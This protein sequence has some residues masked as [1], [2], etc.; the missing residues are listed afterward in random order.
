M[1][2]SPTYYANVIHPSHPTPSLLTPPP[3]IPSILLSFTS[4]KLPSHLNIKH[5]ERI[6][7]ANDRHKNV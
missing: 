7:N 3:S 2:V 1:F 5:L 4:R 6:Q